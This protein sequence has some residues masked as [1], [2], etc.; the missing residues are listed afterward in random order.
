VKR[1]KARTRGAKCLV[2]GGVEPCD[3]GSAP[4]PGLVSPW[5]LVRCPQCPPSALA[6][7]VPDR[8]TSVEGGHTLRNRGVSSLE[9]SAEN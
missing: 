5:S 1:P 2:V 7:L 6:A 4:G 8:W 9:P 3:V